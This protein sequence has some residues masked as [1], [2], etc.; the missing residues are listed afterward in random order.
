MQVWFYLSQVDGSNSTKLGKQSTVLW[1][2][3]GLRGGFFLSNLS[4]KLE[5]CVALELVPQA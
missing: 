3:W 4:A 2:Y 1:T 5:N